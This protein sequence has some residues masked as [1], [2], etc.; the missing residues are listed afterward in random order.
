MIGEGGARRAVPRSSA[1]HAQS[2]LTLPPRQPLKAALQ[3][4]FQSLIFKQI[5]QRGKYGIFFT[6]EGFN[7]YKFYLHQNY[8]KKFL[9]I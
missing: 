3:L 1:G 7:T 4:P 8:S 9:V 6:G 2:R 5:F